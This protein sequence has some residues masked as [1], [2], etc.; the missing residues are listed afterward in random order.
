MKQALLDT[1]S[2]AKKVGEDLGVRV[3]VIKNKAG[4]RFPDRIGRL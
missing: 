2:K 4:S 1:L 3:K